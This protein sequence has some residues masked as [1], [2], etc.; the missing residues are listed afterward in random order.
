VPS[1]TGPPTLAAEAPLV[2]YGEPDRE[3]FFAPQA[4]RPL[5]LRHVENRKLAGLCKK[6]GSSRRRRLSEVQLV[7]DRRRPA[8]ASAALSD[9]QHHSRDPGHGGQREPECDQQNL[10]TRRQPRELALHKVQLIQDLSEVVASLVSLAQR[11]P[12]LRIVGEERFGAHL[13]R[14]GLPQPQRGGDTRQ[15]A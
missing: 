14:Y 4:Q 13:C 2:N 1:A 11:Q 5:R 8:G 12:A 6:M 10:A 9:Q 15:P 3:L 7:L